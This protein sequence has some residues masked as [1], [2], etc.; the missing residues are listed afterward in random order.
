M[1][2]SNRLYSPLRYPGGKGRFAPFITD[3][4]ETN[5]L[6]GCTY[7][8]PFAG[9]AAVALDLLFSGVAAHI[10]INDLDEAIHAF[11]TAATRH[12]DELLALLDESAITIDEWHHWRAVLLGVEA[13]TP[14]ERGFATLFL[15]RT[16]RSGILKAGVI[17]GKAQ[18]GK[19]RLNARFNKS[20]IRRRIERIGKHS[21]SI[22]VHCEDAADL[23]RRST[24]LL[25]PTSFVYL[26]PPY[27]VKGKGL[28]RNFY[29]PEDH[30]EIAEIVQS[31]KLGVPWLVS[32]DAAPEIE[33]LYRHSRKHTYSLSYSA[34]RQYAGAEAMFFSDGLTIPSFA[35]LPQRT[36]R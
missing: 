27:F 11:W 34:Q 14:S 21:S 29:K 26:D 5:D 16:N 12:V 35:K 19:Y 28:Y 15:N 23:L 18:E 7:L 3:L 20:E 10:H 2:F 6:A 24:T 30:A 9:G 13:A 17:G 22:T 8:E 25:P 33:H 36:V 32:Y 31:G 4:I 1:V